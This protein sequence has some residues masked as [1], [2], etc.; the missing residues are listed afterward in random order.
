[1]WL[2]VGD[3]NFGGV[4]FQSYC[5]V[6]LVVNALCCRGVVFWVNVLLSCARCSVL[7]KCFSSVGAIF[8]K[9]M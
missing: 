6:V 4:V 8:S 1:M 2:D 7:R 9:I 5:F 3:S